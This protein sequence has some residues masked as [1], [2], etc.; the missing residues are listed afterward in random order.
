M[1]QEWWDPAA[2][3]TT[4]KHIFHLKGENNES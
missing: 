3:E 1:K 4:A 2:E